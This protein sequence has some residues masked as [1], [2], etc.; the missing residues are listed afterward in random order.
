MI[1]DNLDS[2]SNNEIKGF[3]NSRKRENIN[4]L[5]HL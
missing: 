5:N 1:K 3:I 2:I 4:N